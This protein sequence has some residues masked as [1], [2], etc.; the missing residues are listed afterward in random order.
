MRP[1]SIGGQGR[2]GV[3]TRIRTLGGR[4]HNATCV[5]AAGVIDDDDQNGD[6]GIV[7]QFF[8]NGDLYDSV[9]LS[10]SGP[11]AVTDITVRTTSTPSYTGIRCAVCLVPQLA[12]GAFADTAGDYWPSSEQVYMSATATA[13]Q[14]DPQLSNNSATWTFNANRTIGMSP[15]WLTPG[16]TPVSLMA[17]RFS[18][19]SLSPAR[20]PSRPRCG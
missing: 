19:M 10:N 14:R 15:A 8:D 7:P 12:V 9:R 5:R 1:P 20:P 16:T 11:R 17:T 6:V 13:R 18:R 4:Y 3:R 2:R